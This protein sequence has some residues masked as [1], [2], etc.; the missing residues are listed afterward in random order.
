MKGKTHD[1][2]HELT[3]SAHTINYVC[4]SIR[5]MLIVL[6]I[7]NFDLCTNFL[8]LFSE[9]QKESPTELA[10]KYAV[11]KINKAKDV[12]PN[13]SLTYDIQ[14]VPSEDSFRTTKK[15]NKYVISRVFLPRQLWIVIYY[16]KIS[17]KVRQMI[18]V[19]KS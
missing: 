11:F 3:F 14:Y 10:F 17:S 4:H 19:M 13:N 1:L 2:N 5:S 9:E 6:G 18:P 8:H 12:L 15:V 16:V 7:Y